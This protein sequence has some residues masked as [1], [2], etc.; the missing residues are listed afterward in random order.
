MLKP[1]ESAEQELVR[2][3]EQVR[4][5][6]NVLLQ[7]HGIFS[8]AA[9]ASFYLLAGLVVSRLTPVPDLWRI[10]YWVGLAAVAALAWWWFGLRR[11]RLYR[12]DEHIALLIQRELPQLKDAPINAVQLRR[13]LEGSTLFSP[14]LVRA[15]VHEA[16]RKLRGAQDRVAVREVPVTRSMGAAALGVLLLG[17]ASLAVPPGAPT[18]PLPPG[19]SAPAALEVSDL[20]VLYRYPQYTGLEPETVRGSDGVLS[21][22]KGTEVRLSGRLAPAPSAGAL[23]LNGKDRTPLPVTKDGTFNVSFVLVEEGSYRFQGAAKGG[24]ALES[25]ERPI[26]LLGDSAPSV[27]IVSLSPRPGED[28]VVEV[29]SGEMLDIG[30]ACSDD[31][32]V[33]DVFIGYDPSGR[34]DVTKLDRPQASVSGTY[35]WQLPRAE[36][37]LGGELTFRVGAEDADNISGPNTGF[38]RSVTVRIITD[39]MLHRDLVA[40]QERLKR[41]MVRLLGDEL[42]AWVQG[43]FDPLKATGDDLALATFVRQFI[44]SSGEVIELNRLILAYMQSDPLADKTL[45]DALEEMLHHRED[46]LRMATV[47][48]IPGD[49]KEES[50]VEYKRRLGLTIGTGISE[51]EQDVIK[52]DDLLAMEHVRAAQR[53]AERL[54]QMQSALEDLLRQAKEGKLTAE[55]LAQLKRMLADMKRMMDELSRQVAQSARQVEREF[56]NPDALKLAGSREQ[57]QEALQ[58]LAQQAEQG[59]LEAALAE[60]ERL[61]QQLE[62]MAGGWQATG[63]SLAQARFG[64]EYAK[65]KAL[66]AGLQRIHAEEKSLAQDTGAFNDEIRSRL[67]RTQGEETNKALDGVRQKAERLAGDVASVKKQLDAEEGLAEYRERLAKLRA[68]LDAERVKPTPDRAGDIARMYEEIQKM[69]GPAAADGLLREAPEALHGVDELRASLGKPDIDAAVKDAAQ[70]AR[71]LG[72]WDNAAKVAG[73]AEMTRG[74]TARAASTSAE[75][76]KDLEALANRLHE[77]TRQAASGDAGKPL[78]DMAQRQGQTAG[79]LRAVREKSGRVGGTEVNWALDSATQ[80]MDGAR[81]RLSTRD[82]ETGFQREKVALERLSD[83]LKGVGQEV[84]KLKA[85]MQGQPARM[86]VNRYGRPDGRYGYR[87]D[88]VKIPD[89]SAYRVPEEFRGAITKALRDGLPPAYREWNEK[90]Y[91][92]LVK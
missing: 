65:L 24:R 71:R 83:A 72:Q 78:D 90:Y 82:G 14:A 35:R 17:V 46:T 76:Q 23:V 49:R 75:I 60:A 28:G 31:F 12:S 77:A 64:D 15:Y 20:S 41:L 67:S 47:R 36:S 39:E 63:S 5:R 16:S 26:H 22:V 32:G 58:R 10:V 86:A 13:E 7:W 53:I 51:L 2:A 81:E 25:A 70:V 44:T 40:Q 42:A 38:S 89:E 69:A 84:E 45:Y 80:H 62:Q 34:Q 8:A 19:P 48:P 73:L 18:A 66:E 68:R 33:S 61:K 74:T 56:L 6:A 88:E 1:H 92:E 4:T 29:R 9:A 21:G 43:L 55:Q 79:G 87:M 91:E 3:I 27:R 54:K 37:W 59:E 30:Y 50:L 52:L 85:N 11:R 57:M